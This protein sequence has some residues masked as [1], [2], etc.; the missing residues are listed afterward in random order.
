MLKK[1]T[2]ANKVFLKPKAYEDLENIYNYSALNFGE[3]KAVEYIHSINQIFSKLSKD[4]V[5]GKTCDYIKV[6]LLKLNVNSHVIF[7]KHNDNLIEVIRILHQQQDFSRH[8]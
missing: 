5:R 1:V 8:L 6:N 4:G 7:Y 2:T 3:T